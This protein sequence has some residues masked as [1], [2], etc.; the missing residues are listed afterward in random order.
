MVFPPFSFN[1][2]DAEKEE[3]IAFIE[4]QIALTNSFSI[5]SSSFIE[6]FFIR[7]DPDKSRTKITPVNVDEAQN[8]AQELGL[9]RYA[10]V[11]AWTSST[12]TQLTVTIRNTRDGASIRTG[13]F[14]SASLQQILDGKGLEGDD[15]DFQENL[16]VE[17]KG[18]GFADYLVFSLLVLQLCIGAIMVAGKNPGVLVEIAWGFGFVLFLF[19][20][21]H[22]QSANMDYVQRYIANGG[23]LRIGQNTA[24]AKIHAVLRYGPILLMNGMIYIRQRLSGRGR[25]PQE[26]KHWLY[27]LFHNWALPWVVISAWLFAL[28]FPSFVSLRGLGFLSWVC[29]IPL[30]W[31]LLTSKVTVAVFY[32]VVFGTIQALLIN[33]WHGTYNYVTLHLITIAFVVEYLLFMVPFVFLIKISGKYGFITAALAWTFFDLLRSTGILGYPWGLIGT[34]QY[35]FLP[36][37]QIASITGVWGVGFVVLL[38]NSCIAWAAAGPYFGW[39]WFRK[40]A[41]PTKPHRFRF[42]LYR[43]VRSAKNHLSLFPVVIGVFVV[44]IAVSIGGLML[45]DLRRRMNEA[46]DNATVVLLQQNTDPRKHEYKKNTDKLMELTDQAMDSLDYT[47]DLVAWPEGGFKLDV[48]YWTSERNQRSYWGRVVTEFLDY[49]RNLGTWLATGTQ[50]PDLS[51]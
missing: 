49:Q 28:S 32:G 11:T 1:L 39:S 51:K 40:A 9:E 34:T 5:V 41:F 3:T 46:P 8:I 47:P 37:I 29:L 26:S 14:L 43:F 25:K 50:D 19:A 21:I 6:E 10:I 44:T 18:F 42:T 20:F 23:Q 4:K 30:F 48:R 27:S 12:K 35:Q 22:A 2:T 45:A 36:L 38:V 13:R 15:L 33:Y 31:V 7:T 16:T 17:M 24:Q